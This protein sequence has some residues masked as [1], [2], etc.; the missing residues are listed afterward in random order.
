MGVF[1]FCISNNT[2]NYTPKYPQMSTNQ[3]GLPRTAE[4]EKPLFSRGFCT[5]LD[6][7]GF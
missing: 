6:F 3:V 7:A 1:Y 2:L 4:K 5:R